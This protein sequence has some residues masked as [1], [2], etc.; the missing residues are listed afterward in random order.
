[1]H[2]IAIHNDQVFHW[3]IFIVIVVAIRFVLLTILL[4][5]LFFITRKH[6]CVLD[7]EAL[8]SIR[9]NRNKGVVDFQPLHSKVQMER[10]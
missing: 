8:G 7:L 3:A 10:Q 5:L 4:L 9:I 2:W 1:M 6:D